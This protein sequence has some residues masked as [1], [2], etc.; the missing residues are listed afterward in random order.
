MTG[1]ARDDNSLTH[2][3]TPQHGAPGRDKIKQGAQPTTTQTKPD[4]PP[5][6]PSGVSPSTDGTR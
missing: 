3:A 1:K 6:G 5:S 4:T 2:G